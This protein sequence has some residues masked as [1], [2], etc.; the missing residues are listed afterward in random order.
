MTESN[1]LG[2]EKIGKLVIWKAIPIS[3]GILAF[4]LFFL[5][6]TIFVGHFVGTL[7]IGAITVVLPIILLASSLGM[8]IG[9]GG[10]T[11]ITLALGQRDMDKAN[12]VF[13]NMTMLN[14][15]L[16]CSVVAIGI[17]LEEEMLQFFGAN[18]EILQVAQDYFKILLPCVPFMTFNL[19]AHY[20][21][22]AEGRP[23]AAMMTMMIPAIIN[24][25]LDAVFIVGFGWGIQGAAW[26]TT[27]ANLSISVYSIWFFLFRHSEVKIVR[28]KLRLQL[29]ILKEFIPLG[30]PTLLKNG[31]GSVLIVVLNHVLFSH[32]G[33]MAV[34]MYGILNRFQ[35][36]IVFPLA[37]IV[38][39]FSTIVGYNYGAEKYS[40]VKAAILDSMRLGTLVTA[41]LFTLVM[42]FPRYLV[43]IF[44]TVP[45]L[46]KHTPAAMRLFFLAMPLLAI[47]QVGTTYFQAIGNSKMS[48]FLTLLLDLM[49]IPLVFILPLILDLNGV[50]VAFALA[51]FLTTGVVYFKL[52]QQIISDLNPRIQIEGVPATG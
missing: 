49:I 23:K 46:V 38:Q 43:H 47:Q 2:T 1:K 45:D 3:L 26:A 6:D 10:S 32:G 8:A 25:V 24:V 13:G 7:G 11:I 44:T 40:R 48:L 50:W 36:F 28:N 31:S 19:V 37:G 51:N 34:A 30:I 22:T 17:F 29:H 52:R 35:L 27:I 14:M 9:K 21:M 41:V 4:S 39:S 18:G 15:L 16:T 42:L 5:A 12:T 33:E 20:V